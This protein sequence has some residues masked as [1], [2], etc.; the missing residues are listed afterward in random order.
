MDR[1]V[2]S[3][4]RVTK[5]FW[6]GN[7]AIVLLCLALSGTL[8]GCHL[9]KKKPTSHE[10]AIASNAI[11][12]LG[13]DCKRLDLLGWEEPTPDNIAQW[14]DFLENYWGIKNKEDLMRTVTWLKEGG[15]RKLFDIDRK[16]L[17][18]ATSEQL[19]EMIKAE[20]EEEAYKTLVIARYSY[21]V[22][23]R[24]IPAWDYLR[25]IHVAGWSYL[26]G[27]ISEDEAWEIIMPAA[28][29]IQSRYKSWDDLM[30][31]YLI[32]RE[33]WS[34]NQ[35]RLRGQKFRDAEQWLLKNP[36]SP[37]KKIPWNLNLH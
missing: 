1:K 3:A 15:H 19:L 37:Y 7:C 5:W 28:K 8:T 6:A 11:V 12:A 9:F 22:G 30:R 10:W 29:V 16:R 33:Y 26:V 13:Y 27:Y 35:T 32:G 31:N 2:A 34:L 18:N 14:K 25:I 17:A 4:K 21:E 23:E 20:P 24:G 36:E